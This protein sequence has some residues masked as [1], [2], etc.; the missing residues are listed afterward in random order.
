MKKYLKINT[1]PNEFV[2]GIHISEW[3]SKG[4]SDEIVKP[5]II[6]GLPKD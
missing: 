5:Y 6:I 3:R 1:G 2:C 4:L